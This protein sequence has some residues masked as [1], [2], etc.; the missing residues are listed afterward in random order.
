MP[1]VKLNAS[2]YWQVFYYFYEKYFPYKRFLKNAVWV[3][4]IWE[5][6]GKLATD[7]EIKDFKYSVSRF[8]F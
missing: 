5:V 2:V 4:L 1:D 6:Q 8:H 7:W 3:F